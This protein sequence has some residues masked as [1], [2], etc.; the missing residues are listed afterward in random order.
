MYNVCNS[1][2]RCGC[3]CNGCGGFWNGFWN[4]NT[5]CICRDACG[6]IRVNQASCG[7][8]SAY[9]CNTCAQT[10]STCNTGTATQTNSGC[11][12][13]RGNLSQYSGDAYYVR[14]Y[15]LGNTQTA[16]TTGGS[17][18]AQ[19]NVGCTGTG[20]NGCGYGYNGCARNNGCGTCF[21]CCRNRCPY[22]WAVEDATD[23]T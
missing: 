11:G 1:G 9:A 18:C 10:A 5:Q 19:T 14:L 4:T 6:N 8:Q 13:C 12:R 21:G 2:T 16:S 23:D 17:G 3:G 22:T 15:A 20:Y 7:C